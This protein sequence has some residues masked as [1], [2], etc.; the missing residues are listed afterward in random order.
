MYNKPLSGLTCVGHPRRYQCQ[1]PIRL[2]DDEMLG[3]G[4]TFYAND[5]DE[6][7]AAPVKRLDDPNLNC[8]KPGSTTLLRPVSARST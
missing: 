7:T 3:A 5:R 2:P 8:R 6:F 4:V 1:G